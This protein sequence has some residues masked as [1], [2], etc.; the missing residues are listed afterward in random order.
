MTLHDDATA[1]L[2]AWTPPDAEQAELREHYLKHLAQ[3]P[4]GMWRS[5]RPDHVTASALVLDQSGSRVLLT[6]HKTVNR[7]LQLG[8]HCEPGDTTLAGAALREAT[9]ESGLT[10]LVIGAEPL[11]LS[12]H[13][14]TA[15]GCR[16]A[17]HL[18]VQYLVTTTAGTQ[19]V[20][21]DESHDLSWFGVDALPDGVDQTVRDLVKSAV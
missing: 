13:E 3:Y 8:G 15:G 10:G 19:Y 6:L 21:S 2:T 18:D 14:L 16:G 4:D 12:R 1:T 5:C 9:E 11:L 17:F 20:V 7:W